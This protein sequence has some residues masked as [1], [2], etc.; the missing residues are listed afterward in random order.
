MAR[1][2]EAMIASWKETGSKKRPRGIKRILWTVARIFICSYVGF[3]AVIFLFQSRF[4]YFPRRNVENTPEDIGLSYEEVFFQAAD[5]VK[6]CGWFV[7]SKSARGTLL[8]CH[9]NAGN[10]SHRLYSIHLFNQ[11]H[12]STF[13]FDY[14]GYGKSEGKPSEKG[15]YL[16][17]EAAWQYLR[18]QRQ[19]PAERIIVFGRSLGGAVAAHLASE[20]TPA[21]LIIESAFTSIPD[22]G[23]K[24]YPFLPIRLL[25]RFDYN[26][27]E[28]V[29]HAACPM[30]V[31]HSRN[32]E[33]IPFGHGRQLFEAA[34]EPKEFLEL[35]GSHNDAAATSGEAYQE[36]LQRFITRYLPA[37]AGP[38]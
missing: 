22:L 27:L 16:D 9:G 3:A 8:F 29:Q 15:T 37:V 7:P 23:A 36:S 30:L 6:L 12:L 17:S 25:C 19:V 28:Y 2:I 24:L 11:L 14:R 32:D 31:V 4:V 10:I 33:M 13:I 5:G 20:Q 21:A 34:K 38:R 35:V 18:Q 26:T 1:L